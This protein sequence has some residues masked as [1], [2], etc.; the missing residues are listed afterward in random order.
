MSKAHKA[1]LAEGRSEGR[2]VRRYLG[3]EANRRGADGDG[4]LG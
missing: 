2:V 3:V 1:A 4:R